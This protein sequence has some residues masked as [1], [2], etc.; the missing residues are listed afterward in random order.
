ME[1]ERPTARLGRDA[2]YDEGI[3]GRSP[4]ALTEPVEYLR[5]RPSGPNSRPQRAS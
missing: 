2:L 5:E 4:Q 3:P 1:T